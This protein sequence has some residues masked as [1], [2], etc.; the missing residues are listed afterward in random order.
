M[1]IKLERAEAYNAVIRT[2]TAKAA[3]SLSEAIQASQAELAAA[4]HARSKAQFTQSRGIRGVITQNIQDPI[5]RRLYLEQSKIIHPDK[6]AGCLDYSREK[7]QCL[8]LLW[9]TNSGNRE[10]NVR[11]TDLETQ[12]K[13]SE[14]LNFN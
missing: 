4:V 12:K 8:K 10:G 6:N 5:N 1:I 7:F 13:V 11:G 9:D 3:Q 14:C 2:Q